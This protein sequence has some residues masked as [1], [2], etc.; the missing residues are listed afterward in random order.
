MDVEQRLREV[1][2]RLAL[3]DIEGMYG[4]FYDSQDGA[5]WAGLFTEDGV[6]EGRQLEGMPPQNLIRGRA[7]L[8]RFA[9]AQPSSGMHSMHAPHLV[10]DGDRATG[11]IHFQFQSMGVDE[12][13]R[14]S[15]REVTGFY[16]AGYVRTP[17][18]WR[19][20]RRVTN[21]L[22]IVTRTTF[23]YEPEA[24]DVWAPLPPEAADADYQDARG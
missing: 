7:N 1:E 19:I 20:Q 3:I 8:A 22:E 23:R 11:R 4:R 18:G 21:Y 16:D 2:D 14:T 10:V 12:H 24:A 5:R 13:G 6:Y 9:D 17:E 15:F